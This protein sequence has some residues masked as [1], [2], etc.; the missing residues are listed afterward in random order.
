MPI[1]GGPGEGSAKGREALA[2]EIQADYLALALPVTVKAKGRELVI[3]TPTD[4]ADQIDIE[5]A[6]LRKKFAVRGANAKAWL[7]GFRVVKIT[8]GSHEAVIVPP[9]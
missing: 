3:E 4:T 2:A 1:F 5:A 8:N 6:M 7:V 9:Q